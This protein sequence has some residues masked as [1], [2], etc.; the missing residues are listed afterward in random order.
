M[1]EGIYDN[2]ID[3]ALVKKA[4]RADDFAEDDDY[5]RFLVS[6]AAEHVVKRIGR[7]QEFLFEGYE[8][9]HPLKQAILMLVG[10]WYNQ[11]EAVGQANLAEVPLA[12]EALV[13]PYVKLSNRK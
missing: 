9:S 1:T 6:S 13:K 8:F 7:E 10:H 5:L 4:V 3:L 11:R 12:F 2:V